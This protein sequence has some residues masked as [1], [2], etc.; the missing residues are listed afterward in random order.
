MSTLP[1][2]VTVQPS[3]LI[4]LL[5]IAIWAAYLVQHWLTRREHLATARSMD[6]FSE[7]MRVL[8]R[9]STQA[10]AAEPHVATPARLHRPQVTVDRAAAL[11]TRDNDAAAAPARAAGATAAAGRLA[12]ATARRAGSLAR[13]S[14]ARG[15]MAR[16]A[17]TKNAL[18]ASSRQQRPRA[19]IFGRASRGVLV[20]AA[21]VLAFLSVVLAAAGLTG[22]RW[23]AFSVLLV[24]GAL[25][26]LRREVA[27][28]AATRRP[29]SAS[30]AHA[31]RPPRSASAQRSGNTQRSARAARPAAQATNR[32]ARPVEVAPDTRATAAAPVHTAATPAARQR[33]AAHAVFDIAALETPAAPAAVPAASAATEGGWS[34][35]PVPPPTYTLKARAVY[36]DPAQVIEEE[37]DDVASPYAVTDLAEYANERR[38]ASG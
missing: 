24:G 20:I 13:G 32:P 36:A 19:A 25:W 8:D 14:V 5:V 17:L 30:A 37:D 23:A 3:S 29:H 9:T 11:L 7:A 6:R 34:P 15:S 1:T 16:G 33:P 38:L 27:A 4:F 28:Q 2:V 26:W 21:L 31:A 22:W 10:S 18:G 35:V 12:G